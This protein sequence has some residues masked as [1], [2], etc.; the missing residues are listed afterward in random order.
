MP[1]PKKNEGIRYL[2]FLKTLPSGSKL[3]YIKFI[4]ETGTVFSI[5]SSGTGNRDK[6]HAKAGA[7]LAKENLRALAIEKRLG[8]EQ[9]S[10]ERERLAAELEKARG[11][12]ADQ[13]ARL[14]VLEALRLFW[15]PARSPYLQDLKDAGRPL[16]GHYIAENTKN[17]TRYL[18][19]YGELT[20]LPMTDI[21][22]AIVDDLCRVLRK[23][24]ASRY[25]INSII[26]TLRAPCTWLSARGAMREISFKGI[27]LPEKK[28][29]ERGILSTRELE[30]VV[31]LE[32]APLWYTQEKEPRI[33]TRPRP[34]LPNGAK[35]QGE[36]SIGIREKL[37]VILGAYTGARLGELRALRW[38]DV[39]LERGTISIQWNFTDQDGMKPPKARSNRTV[40]IAIDLENILLEARKIAK[41]LGMDTP[42]HFVLLNPA[43]PEKPISATTIGRAWDRVLRTIG[44]SAKEQKERNLVFHGL[45]HL[46]ATRLVD[47][48]LSP[49]EAAKLTGHRVLATLGRYSDHVQNETLERSKQ[50]LNETLHGKK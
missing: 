45:R 18:S 39:D 5:R 46:F 30:L 19:P 2:A 4:D 42:A 36:P 16:S 22:F 27:T 37:A 48:G 26:N 14:S 31:N 9:T 29:K 21:S 24:G 25:T 28:P 49:G 1:R 3:Y 11:T 15:D 6:A 40:A 23:K 32:T 20:T 7:I 10:R 38:R 13:I 43:D 17:I 12:E 44:I 34:R 8:K 47:A 35:N 50:I 41:D 33:D